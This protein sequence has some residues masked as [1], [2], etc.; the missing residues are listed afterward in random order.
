[1]VLKNDFGDPGE[2]ALAAHLGTTSMAVP[3]GCTPKV[4]RNDPCPCG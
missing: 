1:V 2:I 3:R 4:G